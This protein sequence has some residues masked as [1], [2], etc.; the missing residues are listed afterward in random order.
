MKPCV[1]SDERDSLKKW[2]LESLR[3]D[4]AAGLEQVDKGELIDGKMVFGKLRQKAKFK[5]WQ[6]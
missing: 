4:I 1:F 2:Q 6:H 3:K 5:W